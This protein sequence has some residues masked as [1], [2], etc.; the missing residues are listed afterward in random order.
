MYKQQQKKHKYISVC[1][2]LLKLWNLEY[3]VVKIRLHFLNIL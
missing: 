2:S 3:K 1:D